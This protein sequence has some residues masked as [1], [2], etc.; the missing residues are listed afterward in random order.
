VHALIK[1]RDLD[2]PVLKKL[3]DRVKSALRLPSSVDEP[4]NWIWLYDEVAAIKAE[5]M[6]LPPG[7]EDAAIF[8][9]IEQQVR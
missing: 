8:R 5:G 1:A 3:S 2:S 7:L 9:I 6:P 4:L